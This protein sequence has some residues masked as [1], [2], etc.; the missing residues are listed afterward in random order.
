VTLAPGLRVTGIGGGPF[1]SSLFAI[2]HK[3]KP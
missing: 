3:T 2:V 1:A